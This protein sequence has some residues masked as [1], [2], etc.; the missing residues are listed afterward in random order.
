MPSLCLVLAIVNAT[1]AY[2][3]ER[4]KIATFWTIAIY[5]LKSTIAPGIYI[6]TFIMTFLAHRTRSMPFCFVHR[7]PGRNETGESRFDS[8]DEV[9]QPLVR[10]AIL[11]VITRLFALGLLLLSLLVDLDTLGDDIIV[12]TTGWATVA[13]NPTDSSAISIGLSLLPMTLVSLLCLY[14]ACL[15]WRYGCEFSMVIPTSSF[16]AWMFPVIGALAMFVGQT[17][18]P[19]LYLVTSNSG[20]LIYMLAMTRTLYEIRH[21]I[22]QA[23]DLGN[24]LNALESTHKREENRP[25][26]G[27]N[28]VTYS[29]REDEE[30][31][32]D[33]LEE[34]TKISV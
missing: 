30:L 25:D 26:A 32:L 7:G 18:G 14:F 6:F 28:D 31:G 19:D 15:L 17:F 34:E 9:Y 23:G 8:E 11:V 20:I 24:F 12:G 16:N 4:T 1:M 2:D 10:P 5:M 27:T 21:D 3:Y 33:V 13:N 22:R 29:Q